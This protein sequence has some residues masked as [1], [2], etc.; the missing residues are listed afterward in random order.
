MA[1]KVPEPT[2]TF[3]SLFAFGVL[4]TSLVVKRKRNY[5]KPLK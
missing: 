1:T 3:G 5:T 4:G 2:T